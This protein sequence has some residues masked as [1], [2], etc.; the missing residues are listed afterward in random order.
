MKSRAGRTTQAG[1][2]GVWEDPLKSPAG[3]SFQLAVKLA[4]LLA[5]ACVLASMDTLLCVILQLCWAQ[6][7]AVM[8]LCPCR[9]SRH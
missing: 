9:T 6:Q 1:H 4:M 8:L 7:L 3:E 2:T 5:C